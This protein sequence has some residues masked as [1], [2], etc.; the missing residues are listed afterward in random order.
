MKI[1]KKIISLLLTAALILSAAPALTAFADD[2]GHLYQIDGRTAPTATEFGEEVWVCTLCGY[3]EVTQIAPAQEMSAP[4][5]LKVTMYKDE[6]YSSNTRWVILRVAK[7]DVYRVLVS[8]RNAYVSFY[9]EAPE[10]F[11]YS[12]DTTDDESERGEE[13]YLLDLSAGIYYIEVSGLDDGPIDLT[14]TQIHSA[15]DGEGPLEIKKAPD[16]THEGYGTFFCEYCGEKFDCPIPELGHDYDDESCVLP[17][18][19]ADGYEKM[20]CVRCGD[21]RTD[22]IPRATELKLDQKVETGVLTRED[23]EGKQTW[24]GRYFIFKPDKTE[25]YIFRSYGATEDSYAVLYQYYTD[26]VR[27]QV[28]NTDTRE[29]EYDVCIV[30]ELDAGETYLFYA[31]SYGEDFPP[32][33]VAISVSHMYDY[34]DEPVEVFTEP[35]CEE[36]GSGKFICKFCGEGFEA[37]IWSLGHDY[38]TKELTL[39]TLTSDG[40]HTSVCKRCGNVDEE[41][42]TAALEIKN[43][44]KT[45]VS[46]ISRDYWTYYYRYLLFTPDKSEGYRI[47]TTGAADNISFYLYDTSNGELDV[48]KYSYNYGDGFDREITARF[49]AGKTYL[50][51]CGTGGEHMTVDV[52]VE[53]CHSRADDAEPVKTIKAATCL[54]NGSGEFKCEFCGQVYTDVIYALWHDYK[55][56][57]LVPPTTEAGGYEEFECSRCGEKWTVKYQPALELKEGANT[58]I[59][60]VKVTEESGETW[61][62]YARFFIFVPSKSGRYTVGSVGGVKKYSDIERL[63]IDDEKG[64]TVDRMVSAR[65]HGDVIGIT[66]DLEGGKT[67][68][69]YVYCEGGESDLFDMTATLTPSAEL[70]PEYQPPTNPDQ[71]GPG[72]DASDDNNDKP[73]Y[74]DLDGKD[75]VTAADARSALRIAVKLDPADEATL[76]LA[77]VDGVD[78]VTAADARLILRYAVKLEASFPVQKA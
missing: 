54:D 45:T 31:G 28:E 9:D 15:A 22:V 46:Q 2:C 44:S 36:R 51:Y 43:G 77:D 52:G 6:S 26:G 21:V 3:R 55:L 39:P 33:E 61:D 59:V 62:Q 41:I 57:S 53:I 73:V 10:S 70:T 66:A 30:T 68:Y 76:K 27:L 19:E 56:K 29:G 40:K 71:D 37:P 50:L 4:G 18:A 58:R 63:R 32:Y 72:K 20:K 12:Y 75:G 74:G 65:E 25:G 17:T 48:E 16:C 64:F 67:Y 7:H 69:Y 24:A 11:T 14:V 38:E 42:L 34:G 23:G 5:S 47:F 78:G 60:P 35:T 13:A 1:T 8:D 49:E